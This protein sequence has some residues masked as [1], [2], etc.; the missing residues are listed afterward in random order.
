ML[1][2]GWM[3]SNTDSGD[4]IDRGLRELAEDAARHS[5][6]SEQRL[7]RLSSWVGVAAALT[8]A[9]AGIAFAFAGS[10]V[11]SLAV[12]SAAVA[13][14]GAVV[15]FGASYFRERGAGGSETKGT[16][17]VLDVLPGLSEARDRNRRA[18]VSALRDRSLVAP[19]R[20]DRQSQGL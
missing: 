8:S 2:A 10:S 4:D 7:E 19:R 18:L 1:T 11:L 16:K 6:E 9:V 20:G 17:V 15:G 13:L 5:R 14:I 3:A 12:L